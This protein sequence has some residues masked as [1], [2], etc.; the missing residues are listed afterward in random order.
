MP[1]PSGEWLDDDI[2]AY[3]LLG[4]DKLVC[5][6]APE[7]ILEFGLS[8]ERIRC[9]QH[10]IGFV[11][12][13]IVDRALPADTGFTDLVRRVHDDIVGGLS[14]S[15]HCR[16]GIGR[17]GMLAGCVLKEFGFSTEEAISHISAARGTAIPDTEEQLNYVRMYAPDP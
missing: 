2:R 10:G 8:D 16:V 6:L 12:Y 14:V 13:P 15:V 1:K 3:R 9:G 11:G 17:S 7:E 5:L 4:I